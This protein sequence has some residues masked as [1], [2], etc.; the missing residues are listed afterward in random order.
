M[1]QGAATADA[2]RGKRRD[3][4]LGELGGSVL[5]IPLAFET[6]G[7]WG[8]AAAA[9]LRPKPCARGCLPSLLRFCLQAKAGGQPFLPR[10]LEPWEELCLT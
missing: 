2:E 1:G 7:Q 6:Y 3:Y 8:T 5:W 4:A 9:A 10:H